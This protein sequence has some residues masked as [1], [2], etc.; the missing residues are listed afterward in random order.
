MNNTLGM[1]NW[2]VSEA[3]STACFQAIVGMHLNSSLKLIVQQVRIKQWV[4]DEVEG[5]GMK[6]RGGG[7]QKCLCLNMNSV[8]V[9]ST[10]L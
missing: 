2:H 8:V 7:V 4:G 1:L 3:R 10:K 9:F 6:L 5:R